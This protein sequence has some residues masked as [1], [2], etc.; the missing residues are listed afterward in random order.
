MGRSRRFLPMVRR[1][2]HRDDI[3]RSRQYP[4]C[5]SVRQKCVDELKHA[6]E[7]A[8][9]AMTSCPAAACSNKIPE[10]VV[11]FCPL[12]VLLRSGDDPRQRH[13]PVNDEANAPAAKNRTGCS[14]ATGPLRISVMDPRDQCVNASTRPADLLAAGAL[15]PCC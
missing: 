11:R 4:A 7:L 5:R 1:G 8:G 6:L 13:S 12:S 14:T 9:N 10:R 15:A 3:G 2:C